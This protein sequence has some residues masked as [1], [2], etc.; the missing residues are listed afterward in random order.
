MKESEIALNIMKTEVTIRKNPFRPTFGSIPEAIAGRDTI[1]ADIV[2]GLENVPG[3]PNRS[4]IFV[5]PRGCGKTVLMAYIAELAESQGWISINVTSGEGMLDEMLIQVRNKAAH[6]LMPETRK[7]IS[8]IHFGGAGLSFESNRPMESWRSVMTGILNELN[9]AGTGLLVTIDEISA[10]HTEL[11][12]FTDTYQHFVREK[13]NI[14]ML[15]AGLPHNVN[16]LLQDK[17]ST[18]LRRAFRRDLEPIDI[19][20][21]AYSIRKTIENGGRRI[22]DAALTMAA[23]YSQGYAYLI[24]LIGYHMWKQSD[25]IVITPEE[26]ESAK[27]FAA[28]EMKRTIFDAVLFELSGRE[29]EFVLQ[30][31]KNDSRSRT[32]DIAKEMGISSNNGMQIRRRLI[33][34]NVIRDDGHGYIAFEIPLFGDYLKNAF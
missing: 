23:E 13:R 32:S 5:G 34:R 15:M 16:M 6:I 29:R 8:E 7:T 30:L 11:K 18:Y 25:S 31:S 33:E 20:D 19:N 26:V 10:E 3:D 27:A 22:D 21:V 14:A 17:H 28:R 1:I 4:T 9:D 2:S 12:A 24:Q